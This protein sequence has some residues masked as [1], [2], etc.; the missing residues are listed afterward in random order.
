[1][2]ACA[3]PYDAVRNDRKRKEHG[4]DSTRECACWSSALQASEGVFEVARGRAGR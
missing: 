2:T 3:D 4:P 1:M